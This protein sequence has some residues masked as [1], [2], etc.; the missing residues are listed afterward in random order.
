M[1]ERK[2]NVW[3]EA[4]SGKTLKRTPLLAMLNVLAQYPGVAPGVTP[5]EGQHSPTGGLSFI[6]R[7]KLPILG[8]VQ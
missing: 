1:A 8:P 2:A 7:V 6:C 3:K 5:T 4:C